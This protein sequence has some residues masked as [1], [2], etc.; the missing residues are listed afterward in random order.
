MWGRREHMGCHDPTQ[1]EALPAMWVAHLLH[2]FSKSSCLPAKKS[3]LLVWGR[4]SLTFR[5]FTVLTNPLWKCPVLVNITPHNILIFSDALCYLILEAQDS[6]NKDF[7]RS[8]EMRGLYEPS[9]FLSL[10]CT[11]TKGSCWS[12]WSPVFLSLVHYFSSWYRNDGI[13][14]H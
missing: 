2:Q 4:V 13:F 7:M 1:A 5:C 10:L 8:I 12:L 11:T 14:A 3:S 9:D 6:Y